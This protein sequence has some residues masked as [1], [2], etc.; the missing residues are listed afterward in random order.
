MT[1][2]DRAEELIKYRIVRAGGDF[3]RRE[4]ERIGGRG[5]SRCV[6]ALNGREATH[7]ERILERPSHP[8]RTEVLIDLVVSR[9]RIWIEGGAEQRHGR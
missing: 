3:L 4:L 1:F 2:A 5:A 6:L 7:V 8:D 9:I